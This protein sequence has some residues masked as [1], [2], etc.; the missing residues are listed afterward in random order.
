M[1]IRD[2]IVYNILVD[3]ILGIVFSFVTIFIIFYLTVQY[4]LKYYT[5]VE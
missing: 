5:Y 4:T 3:N 2:K 1:L